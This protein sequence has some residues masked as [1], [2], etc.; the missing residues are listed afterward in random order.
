L[1]LPGLEFSLVGRPSRR[2]DNILIMCPVDTLLHTDDTTN[3]TG[4]TRGNSLGMY[5]EGDRHE[6]RPGYWVNSLKFLF[7]S[8]SR[9]KEI[10]R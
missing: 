1:H 6:S 7:I 4:L 10:E 5:L 8:V 9:Y 3:T 2:N